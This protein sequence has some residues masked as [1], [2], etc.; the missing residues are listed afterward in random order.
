VDTQ[1]R[2]ATST[3]LVTGCSSGIGRA[4]ASRLAR[5]GGF[6]VYASARRLDAIE[7]LRAE[8]CRLLEL[9]VA[10]DESRRSAVAAAGGVDVL[11]NNAGY[12][13]SGAVETVTLD[14]IRRQFETNVFGAVALAQLVL[15]HMR[16]QRRGRIV[17]VSSMGGRLTFPG[18][19][20]YHASKHALEAFSDALRFEVAGFGVDVVV[21]EPGIIRTRFAETVL[22]GLPDDDGPYA[23][24]DAAVG[25][26]TAAAYESGPLALLGGDADDVA[27]VI[28]KAIRA[29]KPRTRYRVTASAS[30]MLGLR[31]ALPDRAWDAVVGSSYPR[32]G[33]S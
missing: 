26:T 2:A 11:V 22:A 7:D 13:Q 25:A 18:A 15:P 5:A 14:D 20:A 23:A 10:D 19:G 21:V 33:A 16:E 12:S 8:G 29:R 6:R 17:N 32:P 3:V 30:L 27:R 9:D 1:R 28:E 4:T 31:R 24:F